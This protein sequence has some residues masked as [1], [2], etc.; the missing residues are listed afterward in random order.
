MALSAPLVSWI[1]TTHTQAGTGIDGRHYLLEEQDGL[2]LAW[3]DHAPMLDAY[4]SMDA[5]KDW[6]ETQAF[7]HAG[8][9]SA[10]DPINA[11]LSG[12]AA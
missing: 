12:L 5:A 10:V 4:D 8:R 7:V 3:I 6:A 11:H 1:G 2:V 9:P